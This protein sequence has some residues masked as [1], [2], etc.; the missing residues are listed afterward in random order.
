ML[1]DECRIDNTITPE[2]YMEFRKIVGWA[3]FPLEQAQQGLANSAYICCIRKGDEAIALGRVIWDHGYVV[4]IADVIVLPEYQ[5]QGLGRVIMELIMKQIG[6]WLKPGY[7]AMVSLSS[8]KGKEP[9][10]RK[11]GFQSRPD[12]NF[13]C[14]MCQWMEGSTDI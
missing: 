2:E 13:G 1:I 10:Y 8:A 12:E 14:G 6:E 3:L 11:F 4:Y 9:F 7:K 5:G